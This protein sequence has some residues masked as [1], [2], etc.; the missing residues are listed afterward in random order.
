[1]ISRTKRSAIPRIVFPR[2]FLWG[3]ATAATQ[4]DGGD[5]AS[6]WFN[7]CKKPGRI[8]DNSS[9]ISA[10]DHWNHY[11][12]DF[13]IMQKMKL[14]AYRLGADWSR[15]QKT[16]GKFDTKALDHFRGMLDSLRRKKIRPLLTLNHFTLPQWWAARGG[17][18]RE[19]NLEDFYKYI[20]FIVEGT[21]DLVDEYITIN[22]P[23]VYCLLSY[24]MGIWPPGESGFGGYLD[25]MRAQRNMVI[26]H[27]HT[28]DR[29]REIHARKK[30]K[31]PRIS[32]AQHIRIMDPLNSGS[33]LD[34][35]RANAA[36]FR[37]NRLFTDAVHEG[38]LIRPLG[39]GETIHD[40]NAWD[41]FGINYYSRNMISFNLFTPHLLFIK[42]STNEDGPVNQ[43]G[44]EIYP[45]GL[46]RAVM[47]AY[48]RYRLPVR[49]T[50]NGIATSDDLHRS[51][52]IEDHLRAL[53]RAME[54]GVPVE[55]YYHWSFMDNF[56]WAEGYT[57]PFGLVDV[58][59]NNQKRKPRDSM[60]L[61]SRIAKTGTL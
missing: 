54:L 18:T 16:P 24:M 33:L 1:M 12:E 61:Y 42:E 32:I 52:Y 38:K 60:L 57:A 8:K 21:G 43:L 46:T 6:D 4:V 53:H 26:A 51:A 50:E 36:D 10:C 59:F 35:D 29:I 30:F 58:N 49:I 37:F 2:D 31:S 20:D 56:E 9:C 28:Y 17:W 15:F 45:E 23:N 19:S 47:S 34:V 44:W 41:F 5:D 39:N 55:G 27:C 7:Y 48:D 25:G 13:R 14:N 22:E 3:S 40:G 11:E